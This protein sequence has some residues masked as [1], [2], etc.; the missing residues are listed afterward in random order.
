[1]LLKRK[2]IRLTLTPNP[3]SGT[4]FKQFRTSSMK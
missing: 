2:A 1:M 3:E 4:D